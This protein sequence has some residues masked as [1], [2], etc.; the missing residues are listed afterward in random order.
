MD[1]TGFFLIILN[2]FSLKDF[3]NA[4]A[5]LGLNQ[6]I[7]MQT[8]VQRETNQMPYNGNGYH[9]DALYL[10]DHTI[11]LTKS[12]LAYRNRRDS[13]VTF[14][15]STVQPKASTETNKNLLGPYEK[16]YLNDNFNANTQAKKAKGDTLIYNK[17]IEINKTDALKDDKNSYKQINTSFDGKT[18]TLIEIKKT[19]GPKNNNN[20]LYI[21]SECK[22]DDKDHCED[23]K[24]ICYKHKCCHENTIVIED[25]IAINT[26]EVTK[27]IAFDNDK[28]NTT[29]DITQKIHSGKILNA[30]RIRRDTNFDDSKDS[31]TNINNHLTTNIAKDNIS[32]HFNE[33]YSVPQFASGS[34][35][36]IISIQ[37]TKGVWDVIDDFKNQLTDAIEAE[38][39]YITF[40]VDKKLK[41][42]N[43][44]SL[45][46]TKKYKNCE[47]LERTKCLEK[48]IYRIINVNNKLEIHK[49]HYDLNI[50]DDE[51]TENI[52]KLLTKCFLEYGS[53]CKKALIIYK[54]GKILVIGGEIIDVLTINDVEEKKRR[55]NITL[56]Q[57]EKCQNNGTNLHCCIKYAKILNVKKHFPN[58]FDINKIW[59]EFANCSDENVN[60]DNEYKSFL[61]PKYIPSGY[62]N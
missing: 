23:K 47:V 44:I 27:Y 31:V 9:N 30:I 15:L 34:Q 43:K 57:K 40:G 24:N 55:E 16:E 11:M 49:L 4:D 41:S 39:S 59:R 60:N 52:I 13:R 2:F 45:L 32:G 19:N 26:E 7:E 3:S 42:D 36:S 20:I 12:N 14:E 10:T 29:K 38:N 56:G 28:E 54:N 18:Y 62:D 25:S 22:C 5:N 35:C 21:L 51:A 48:N 1:I 53:C 17:D 8:D 61:F 33:Q 50:Y 58:I 46:Q 37:V 6:E